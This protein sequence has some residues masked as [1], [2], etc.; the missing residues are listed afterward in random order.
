MPTIIEEPTKEEPPIE[1]PIDGQLEKEEDETQNMNDYLHGRT[2]DD[3]PKAT[4]MVKNHHP[5]LI[6]GDL[7][8]GMT[9]RSTVNNVCLDSA[10]VSQ[11]VPLNI[12]QALV[13]PDEGN[14]IC[15]NLN[16]IK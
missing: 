9:T 15:V 2:Y 12:T 8:R 6:I 7:S 10:Y 5:N 4:I 3:L 14:F 1:G 11:V 13:D 16:K